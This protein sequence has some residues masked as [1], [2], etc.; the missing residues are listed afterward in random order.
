[1]RTFRSKLAPPAIAAASLL[2]AH[3]YWDHLSGSPSLAEAERPATSQSIATKHAAGLATSDGTPYTLNY[4]DRSR[5][6]SVWHGDG[7]RS[8]FSE[9]LSAAERAEVVLLG[10]VHDCAIT[11]KLQEILFAR[12]AASRPAAAALS[13]EMFESDVQHVLDEYLG[14]LLREQD[15]MSDARP[16]SNYTAHYRPM[17]ELAKAAG[18]PVIAA[19]PPRR[20]VSAA[21]RI[22]PEVL[23]QRQWSARL[24][25]DLPPLPLPKPSAEY[26]ARLLR[27]KEVAPRDKEVV[28]GPLPASAVSDGCPYIGLCRS[29]ARTLNW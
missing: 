18:L 4:L 3:H 16:W 13:L 6:F 20:Y 24:R 21:G 22:G 23:T 15:L 1:M 19:N 28:A 17:V 27:D 7:R 26:T 11:H 8:S 9:M 12:L 25:A 14:G 5:R 2:A 29:G 10:E